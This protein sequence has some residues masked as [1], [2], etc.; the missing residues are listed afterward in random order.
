M[1]LTKWGNEMTLE[2]IKIR[3]RNR[4]IRITASL[5]QKQLNNKDFTVISNNCWGGLV[6]ESYGLSK[7]SPTVGMYFMT[8]EY[9]R[10]IS[11]LDYYISECEMKFIPPEEAR[12]RAFYEQDK[13]FGAYPI[14]RVGDVEIAMLHYHSEEEAKNKW[15][16]R[17]KRIC[18][19]RL[20]VKMNDQDE[21]TAEHAKAFGAMPYA[22]KVFFTVKD[23]DAGDC[24]VRFRAKRNADAII[25]RQEPIG[26]SRQCNVNE[27][28]NSQ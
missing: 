22:H 1:P 14:A 10:F 28:I 27:L 8:E 21:C 26:A 11:N 4:Y 12:H 20:L 23:Y 16:R 2:G 24:T 15:E 5:R 9:L 19:D 17:C 6:Y 18:W 7:Q 3:I 13:R 25:F